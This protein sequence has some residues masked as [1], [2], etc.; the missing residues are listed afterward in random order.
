MS[1]LSLWSVS[2]RKHLSNACASART[3][4]AVKCGAGRSGGTD[5]WRASASSFVAKTF[6]C[7]GIRK[8]KAVIEKADPFD[9]RHDGDFSHRRKCPMPTFVSA[10]MAPGSKP[11]KSEP[12]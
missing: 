5:R 7:A 6:T 4:S 12:I 2:Q 8:P 11:E 10:H 1:G 9:I 3:A